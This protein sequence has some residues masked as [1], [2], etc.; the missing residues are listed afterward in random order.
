[1]GIKIERDGNTGDIHLSQ[2]QYAVDMLEQFKMSDCK[3]VSTDQ[4]DGCKD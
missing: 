1:M 4:R 3:P 2:R